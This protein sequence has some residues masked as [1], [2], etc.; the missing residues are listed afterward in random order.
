MGNPIHPRPM[1]GLAAALLLGAGWSA[2]S[3]A[4]IVETFDPGKPAAAVLGGLASTGTDGPWAM[5]LADGAYTWRNT[6]DAQAVKYI[7]IDGTPGDKNGLGNAS[8]AVDVAIG[9][10]GGLSGAGIVYRF[11]PKGRTYLLFTL[12]GDGQYGAFVRGSSGFKKLASGSVPGVRT[13]ANRLVVRTVDERV[14]FL[15]NDERVVGLGIEGAMGRSVG[16]AALGKGTFT[17]DNLE[18]RDKS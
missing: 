9:D 18:V 7:R 2:A 15:V 14:E 4:D 11:D 5:S 6:A 1:L 17:F 12:L 3:A 16:I 8:V 10:G 13:G